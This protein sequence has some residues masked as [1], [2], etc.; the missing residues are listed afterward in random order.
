VIL[1]NLNGNDSGANEAGRTGADD[2]PAQG[3]APARTMPALREETVDGLPDGVVFTVDEVAGLL[4]VRPETIEQMVLAKEL[5]AV[6]LG[7]E[8]RVPRRA[9]LACLQGMSADEFDEHLH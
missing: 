3:A 8:M 7:G 1:A 4:K 5:R 2:A 6:S 9:L